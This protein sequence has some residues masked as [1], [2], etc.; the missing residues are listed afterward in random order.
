MSHKIPTHLK[1]LR[2]NPGH[3]VLNKREPQPP[4]PDKLPMP[5]FPSGYAREEWNRVIVELYRLKLVTPLDIYPL[6]AYCESYRR[7]R[8]AVE[9]LD[10]MAE[11]DPVMRGQMTRRRAAARRRIR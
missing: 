1:L 11:R 6:A 7:W 4:L 10:E 8:V 3:Q 5:D 2:G 9:T